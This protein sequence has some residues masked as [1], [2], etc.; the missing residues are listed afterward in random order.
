MSLSTQCDTG[1]NQP[2]NLPTMEYDRNVSTAVALGSYP[3]PDGGPLLREDTDLHKET[4]VAR[5]NP[6]KELGDIQMRGGARWCD[7]L[8]I[9]CR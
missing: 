9:F 3:L 6:T 2:P 4:V 8:C 5:P 1:S 7:V